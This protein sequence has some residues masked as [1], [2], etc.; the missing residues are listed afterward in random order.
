MLGLK[1]LGDEAILILFTIFSIA[2][3]VFGTVLGP[4]G[5][6]PVIV[7]LL[8]ISGA[9]ILLGLWTS[10]GAE[11]ARRFLRG[12]RGG[13]TAGRHFR[14]PY[15]SSPTPRSLRRGPRGSAHRT[16]PRQSGRDHRRNSPS[17]EVDVS[18]R[19]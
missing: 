2:M 9:L 7:S 12:I 17:G 3:L 10:V 1:H 4:E 19:Q 15:R 18:V 11:L 14:G 6:A 13:A 16:Q 8:W 5:N